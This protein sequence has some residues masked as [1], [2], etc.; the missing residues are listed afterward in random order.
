[1]KVTEFEK[2]GTRLKKKRKWRKEKNTQNWK[3][4]KGCKKDGGSHGHWKSK[5]T[6]ENYLIISRKHQSQTYFVYD[7]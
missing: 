1:M 5:N 7:N 6:G 2:K 3:E 4:N